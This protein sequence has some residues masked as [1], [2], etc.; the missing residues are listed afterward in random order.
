MEILRSAVLPSAPRTTSP[1]AWA[2]NGTR[3]RTPGIASICGNITRSVWTTNYLRTVAYPIMRETCE[4]WEDHLKALPDGKLVVPDGWSPEHGPTEDGVSYS[5]EIVWDLFNNYV[6]AADA[7][8]TDKD[9]R[10]QDRRPARPARHAENR[11]M[12]TASGMDDRPR[13][14]RTT[15]TGTRR[16]CSPSIRARR[17]A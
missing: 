4:F 14:S 10:D 9:Y 11:Q 12:G 5:Q 2:G 8:G 15:I 17:S 13:R 6:R 7:L 1:A 3:P 16:I